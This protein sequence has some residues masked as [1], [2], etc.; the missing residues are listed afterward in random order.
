MTMN[1]KVPTFTNS[2]ARDAVAITP[3]DGADLAKYPTKGIYVGVA[4]DI[5]VDLI[6]GTA[7]VTFKDVS[8]G[9][10]F[11]VAVKRV[12]AT[13]TTATDIVGVY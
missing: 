5:R 13:G 11:P 9:S 1:K 3:N 2:S 7:P 6:D 12:Y 8:K 10:I 4:G